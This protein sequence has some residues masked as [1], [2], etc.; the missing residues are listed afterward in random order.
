MPLDV[1][2]M[3][4]DAMPDFL[5]SQLV[6]RIN[7]VSFNAYA[8]VSMDALFKKMGNDFQV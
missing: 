5:F 3:A 6:D 2:K 8:D 1:I 4:K 7:E